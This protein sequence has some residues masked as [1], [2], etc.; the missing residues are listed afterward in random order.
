M[1]PDTIIITTNT[2]TAISA[3]VAG[4]TAANQEKQVVTKES[5]NNKNFCSN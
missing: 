2:F 3:A 5:I 4:A 1:F